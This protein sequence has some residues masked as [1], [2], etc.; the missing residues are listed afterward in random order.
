[1]A[2]S[3]GDKIDRSH[4]NT[5]VD[6]KPCVEVLVK[7]IIINKKWTDNGQIFEIRKIMDKT[8]ASCLIQKTVHKKFSRGSGR[9]EGE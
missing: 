4:R 6:R 3:S 7:C 1:M 2:G 5:S 8:D 9:C